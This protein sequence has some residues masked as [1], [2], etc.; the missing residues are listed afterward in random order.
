MAKGKA[1]SKRPPRKLHIKDCLQLKTQLDRA[2]CGLSVVALVLPI[3]RRKLTKCHQEVAQAG[4]LTT[5]NSLG[6]VRVIDNDLKV[7]ATKVQDFI[8]RTMKTLKKGTSQAHV[9]TARNAVVKAQ[10]VIRA[11]TTEAESRC[12]RRS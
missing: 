2:S 11:L 6:H 9:E 4:L 5:F 3:T 8:G 12:G 1:K 7:R 10:D